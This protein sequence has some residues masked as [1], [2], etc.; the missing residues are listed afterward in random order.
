MSNSKICNLSIWNMADNL[1]EYE[2]KEHVSCRQLDNFENK[3]RCKEYI[4]LGAGEDGKA[5][6]RLLRIL[7]KDV[8]AWCD[9]SKQKTGSII[10]GEKIISIQDVLGNYA[11]Q[12]VI[13]ASRKYALDIIQSINI[14]NIP[15]ENVY[16]YDNISIRGMY[17]KEYRKEAVLSYP[18][19]WMTICVTSAC[20]NKC[21]FCSYHGE[22][23]KNVS[24]AY[25]LPFMLS[26]DKFCKMVDMAK[27][28]GVPRIHICGTGEPFLNPDIFKMIDYVID[29]YGV[30]SLQT[31]F[32]KELFEK[33]NYLDE[34]IKRQDYIAYIAT[35]ILSS[36]EDEH[37]KIKQ[38]TKYSELMDALEYLGQNSDIR[39]RAVNILTRNNFKNLNGIIDDLMARNVNFELDLTNLLSYDY[40]DFTS[41]D[42][43]YN[44]NDVEITETLENLKQYAKQKGVKVYIPKPAAEESSC[45]VFWDTFQTWPVRGCEKERYVE[46]MIPHACAAVIRGELS[47]MGYLFDYDNIMDAW[48]NTTLVEIRKNILQ[49]KYPSEWCKKCFMYH[50]KDSYYR[51]GNA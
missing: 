16:D 11:G 42:N 24:N 27:N 41:S 20:P 33:K 39:I 48:N 6:M 4:V 9:N 47:S 13:I 19:L 34:L 36:D 29:Q 22:A 44:S 21:L 35:D 3:R 28:G 23:A 25:G 12:N 31:E 50:E 49:G 37:N 40:S 14:Y 7:G 10:E 43:V 32:W 2:K 38:G 26:Y 15:N 8:V 5:V 30:V 51:K 45:G 1:E 46:N 17:E 18:P